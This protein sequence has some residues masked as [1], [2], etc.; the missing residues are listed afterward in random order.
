MALLGGY[1]A[2]LANS[3]PHVSGDTLSFSTFVNLANRGEIINATVLDQDSYVIGQYYAGGATTSKAPTSKAGS[4][5]GSDSGLGGLSVGSTPTGPTNTSGLIHEFN[6]P[7]LKAA[8]DRSQLLQILIGDNVP[9]TI[10]QQFGKSLLV[11]AT[12]LLPALIIVVVFIYLILSYRRGTGLFG[13]RSGAKKRKATDPGEVTFADVAGQESAVT[14]LR[15]LKEFLS[16]PSRFAALGAEIPRGILLYGPPGCGRTMLARALAAEAGASFFSI[17]GS[18]FVELYVGVGAS[19][20]RDLFREARDAAPSLI[21]IDE[22]DSVGRARSPGGSLVA[23]GEQEQALN[24]ILTEMDGFSSTD[25][26]IVVAATNRPDVLDPALLRPGRFDRTIGL[27]RP[28]EEA[29]LAIL[30]THAK[31]KALDPDVDL[32][33]IARRAVGMTGADLANIMNEAALLAGRARRATISQT[34]LEAGLAAVLSAPERQRRLS[35][36]ERSVG[37]RFTG[38]DQITFADVAG[39]DA[40]VARLSEIRDYLTDPDRFAALGE[41]VPRGVLVFGPP[42]CGKTLLARALASESNAAFFSV[43]ATEFVNTYVGAGAA[44][45]RDMFAEARSMAPSIVFIDELDAVGGSRTVRS[46]GRPPTASTPT[47]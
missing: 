42:G 47:R 21:F 5:L 15:E 20:V 37:R 38:E 6:T 2:V 22:L 25:G 26:V 14:E 27:E 35:M 19:R 29:R 11:P 4:S 40:A 36:R 8:N 10:N 31:G 28:D 30:G 23:Q 1:F 13:I 43:A 24:Q 32:G 18:D 17:S 34:E 7:Y 46:R 45:V 39:Q 9:T 3:K 16:D 41:V 44:R 33:L 12:L